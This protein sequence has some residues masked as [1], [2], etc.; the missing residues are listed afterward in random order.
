MKHFYLLILFL[1]IAAFSVCAQSGPELIGKLESLVE[2][3]DYFSLKEE[4]EVHKQDVPEIYSHYFSAI[5]K[6]VFNDP[7]GSNVQ[8]EKLLKFNVRPLDPNLLKRVYSIKLQNHIDLC[9]YSQAERTSRFIVATYSSLLDST[10][11]EDYQNS[12][13]I[14]TALKD[15]PKQELLRKGDFKGQLTR[16]KMGLFRIETAFPNDTLSF[17]FDTGANFSVMQRSVAVRL[18]MTLLNADFLVTAAT[19]QKVKSDLAV[20]PLIEFG[21]ISL[22]NAVFLVFDDEDL[23]FPQVD[24]QIEGIIG[25]PVIKALEEI[26][27]SKEDELFVPRTAA[28]YENANLSL[29]GLMPIV[30]VKY[31]NDWLLFH[32]DT[33]ATHTALFPA[34]YRKYQEEI[35]RKYSLEKFSAGSA[36]G[37]SEFEGYHLKKLKLGIS[38]S[39]ANLKNV[40][41]Q[42]NETGLGKQFHGN[43]GQDFIKQFGEMVISFKYSAIRFK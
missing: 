6:T 24:Y 21:G 42:L 16:D 38:G 25:F 35:D 27:I 15:S 10:E 1:F 4:F 37:E 26:H 8:I 39:D 33:G 13:K 5:L 40:R 34:F 28:V 19:G 31:R 12:M 20:A 29:D 2:H 23:S 30:R 14:W 7:E 3:K 17:V 11:T 36:G 41:L 32:F 22:K 18:G 43:L 9:E